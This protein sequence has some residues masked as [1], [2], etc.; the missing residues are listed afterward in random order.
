MEWVWKIWPCESE[1][2]PRSHPV[3]PGQEHGLSQARKQR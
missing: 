1:P 3:T 2:W